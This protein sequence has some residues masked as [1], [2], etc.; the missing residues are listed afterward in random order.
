MHEG[1]PDPRTSPRSDQ[2]PAELGEL[3]LGL[4]MMGLVP[5]R[6]VGPISEGAKQRART[7]RFT[8][9]RR[10]NKVYGV[11]EA[12]RLGIILAPGKPIENQD[13]GRRA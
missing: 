8:A 3:D 5:S 12:V 4:E 9:S 1:P 11:S 10:M 13:H 6:P 2:Q 7:D